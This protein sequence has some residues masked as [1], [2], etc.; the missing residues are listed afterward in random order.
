MGNDMLVTVVVMVYKNFS[1]LEATI[2]SVISQK[3]QN[4]ELIVSDD[5]SDNYK[6]LYFSFY[7]DRCSRRFDRYKLIHN[8]NNVG[9]VKHFNNIIKMSNGEIICPLSCGD[10]F[11]DQ[12][13]V[14]DIV[15][16]FNNNDC[17]LCTARR[18]ELGNAERKLPKLYEMKKLNSC[19]KA[20]NSI[21]LYG[22]FIGGATTYYKRELFEKYGYF[23]ERYKLCED[24]P[25]FIKMLSNNITISPLNR[26]TIG[27][28]IS[29]VSSLKNRNKLLDEDCTKIFRNAL[30]DEKKQLF[31]LTKRALN[32]RIEKYGTKSN[33][34]ALS[35]KYIDIVIILIFST[36]LNRWRN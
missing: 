30:K 2:N 29:G 24:L 12:N 15:N 18:K 10:K 28:D 11:I 13:V 7:E 19:R 27:Y 23:D 25:F 8:N 20:L 26:V 22:N 31:F 33:K 1:G 6:E 36:I 21:L 32:Y 4:I 14:T 34:V 9:T 17:M 35:I 16:Y 5:G 3:Y